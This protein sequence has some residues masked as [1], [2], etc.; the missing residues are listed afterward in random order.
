MSVFI[1]H[2]ASSVPLSPLRFIAQ[3]IGVVLLL[4]VPNGDRDSRGDDDDDDNRCVEMFARHVCRVIVV[5]LYSLSAAPLHII[6]SFSIKGRLAFALTD[7]RQFVANTATCIKKC[8]GMGRHSR[9]V[10]GSLII[11]K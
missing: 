4:L 5:V 2:C 10:E 11:A 7:R 1:L 6:P 3:K 9:A 8:G